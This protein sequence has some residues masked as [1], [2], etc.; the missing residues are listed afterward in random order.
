MAVLSVKGPIHFE[1]QPNLIFHF[2]AGN[3][4]DCQSAQWRIEMGGGGLNRPFANFNVPYYE[5]LLMPP[6]RLGLQRA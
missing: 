6:F 5:G 1:Q 3:A 2:Q 4:I